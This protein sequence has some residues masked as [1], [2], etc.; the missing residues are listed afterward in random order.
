[1]HKAPVVLLLLLFS[2][3]NTACEKGLAH[4]DPNAVIVAAPG[5]WWP[6]LRDSVFDA[7]SPDV[8]TLRDERTFRLQ[9]E[10]PT[11]PDWGLKRMFKEVVV[12]GG[13]EE[14]RMAEALGT[15]P[16]TVTVTVP[17]A[18]QT[19]DVW[20]RG[21]NV[22]LILVD[23]QAPV[24]PQV[25]SLVGEVHTAMD[26]RFREGALRRM[27]VTGRNHALADSLQKEAGFSLVLPQVY[28]WAF[29]D[30]LYIF[31]NDNPNPAELIRQF[32]VT[33][34]TPI[35]ESMSTEALMDWKE[36]LSE[37]SYSS[38]QVVDRE[39]LF[40]RN[41]SLGEMQVFEVRGAWLNPPEATWPA[42]GPFLVWTVACPSQDRLYLIDA[43]LYA[44]GKDKWEYILQIETILE[45]FRCG[46][47]GPATAVVG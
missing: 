26:E 40:T 46:S 43:W 22:S 6:E 11:G 21:Q 7:L 33:W 37:E 24:A 15:L 10:D 2:V 34:R 41:L 32:A 12:I 5:D 39:S 31:R 30:S 17:G 14:P 42:A 23:P 28:R 38:A 29:E 13:P 25:F 36:A 4:G 20:A 1:M 35:L 19:E 27:F 8:F 18:F 45:S 47:A 3:F 16:D 44:P 9:Y